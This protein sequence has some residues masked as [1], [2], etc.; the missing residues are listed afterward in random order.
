VLDLVNEGMLGD[1][2]L[3]NGV[4][5]AL[6]ALGA[7]A[8]INLRALRPMAKTLAATTFIAILG[9]SAALVGLL[10]VMRPLLPFMEGF[11]PTQAF[12][13][14]LV[15]GVVVS[16]QSPSVAIAVTAETGA[17][18]PVART[19]LATV[20][21]ADLVVIVLFALVS[22]IARSMFGGAASVGD[23]A[24]DLAWELFGSIGSGVVVGIALSFFLAKIEG[25]RMLFVI[26]LCVVSAEVGQ[27]LHLDPL[28]IAL[29]AGMFVE[30][31]SKRGHELLGLVHAASIPVF[32]LFFAVAGATIHLGVIPHVAIPVAIIVVVRGAGFLAG[33]RVAGSLSGAPESVV[34]WAGFGLLPQAGLAIALALLLVR[35]FPEIGG[36]GELVLGVV[37]INELVAPV[38]FRWSLVKSG[39]ANPDAATGAEH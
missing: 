14:A 18:G 26:G 9:T 11:E 21:I 20:V 3:V 24:T 10:Y 17:N 27:R 33:A 19:V 12:A 1:L 13:A 31:A 6:I 30:N 36:A 28:I 15:V 8:E 38:L 2:K 5:V 34:K 35:T 25:G 4:A 23:A 32:V 22:T 29:A 7:G 39:E 16:A 37:A